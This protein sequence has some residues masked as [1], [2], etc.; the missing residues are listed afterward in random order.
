MTAAILYRRAAV[1]PL[2][3]SKDERDQNACR[4]TDLATAPVVDRCVTGSKRFAE[5][6]IVGD[7]PLGAYTV[8]HGIDDRDQIG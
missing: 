5:V 1:R 6:E 8:K 3:V 2:V 7:T 4:F